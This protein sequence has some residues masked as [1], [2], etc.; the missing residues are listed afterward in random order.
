ML[1]LT[2]ERRERL[3]SFVTENK[4]MPE[5]VKARLLGALDQDQVPAPVVQR[6]ES[7]IGG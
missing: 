3:K 6:I 5:D 7:R 4:R 1:T 2:P